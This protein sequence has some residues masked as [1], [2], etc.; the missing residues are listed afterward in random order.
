MPWKTRLIIVVSIVACIAL[1]YIV[2]QH[3][4]PP[5][6]GME[7]VP[8]PN[9]KKNCAYQ[10]F[11][12]A[13][14]GLIGIGDAA[15]RITQE[16]QSIL[17]LPFDE[18]IVLTPLPSPSSLPPSLSSQDKIRCTILQS[19]MRSSEPE[20]SAAS[21]SSSRCQHFTEGDILSIVDTHHPSI[22]FEIYGIFPDRK[23]SFLYGSGLSGAV[24]IRYGSSS[25]VVTGNVKATFGT[26]IATVVTTASS[27]LSIPT[28][29]LVIQGCSSLG[30]GG[31]GW[32]TKGDAVWHPR[33]SP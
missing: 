16:K 33:L 17:S 8:I 28:P 7:I 32:Y 23:E 9:D 15:L 5:L 25:V 1:A 20:G 11:A 19:R 14:R 10:I 27:L 29:A 6:V 2:R 13:F 22:P 4:V 21:S 18:M 12:G 3:I 31:Q 24:L 26:F 30:G